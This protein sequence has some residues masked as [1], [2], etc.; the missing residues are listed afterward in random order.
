MNEVINEKL[1]KARA[2]VRENKSWTDAEEQAALDKMDRK[3]VS[4]E[5]ADEDIANEI[6]EL[7][8][9]WSEENG[10]ETDWWQEFADIDDIFMKL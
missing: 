7:M 6:S 8:N 4:L 2:Y 10:E 9:E 3:R 1:V 5:L